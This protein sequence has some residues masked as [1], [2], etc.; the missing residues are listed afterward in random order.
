MDQNAGRPAQQ[1]SS[2]WDGFAPGRWKTAIDVRDFIVRNVTPYNGDE[3]F[4]VAPSARTKAVWEKLQPYFVEERKKGVLDVV[5]SISS[6]FERSRVL[7]AMIDAAPLDPTLRTAFLG[8]AGRIG[9]SS[10]RR[11][12]CCLR[13]GRISIQP[14][15]RAWG[16]WCW[17]LCIRTIWLRWHYRW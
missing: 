12:I 3:K 1:R 9:S 17:S 15:R 6:D 8:A 11:I 16:K 10:M 2:A 4:L 7:R 14:Y 5:P 13:N